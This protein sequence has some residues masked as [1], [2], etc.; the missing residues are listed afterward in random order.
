MAATEASSS[1]AAFQGPLYETSGPYF[2]VPFNAA[3]VTR[4]EVGTATLRVTFPNSGTLTYSVDGVP[5]T[6]QIR[7]QT[8]AMNDM[9]GEYTGS[10]GIRV[11][12]GSGCTPTVGG[13]AFSS[14]GSIQLAQSQTT[15]SMRGVLAGATCTFSGSYAQEGRLGTSTGTYSCSNGTSGTYTVS[16]IEATLYGF[17][18]KYTGTERG[19]AVEG[20]IGAT[21]TTIRGFSE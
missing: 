12:G 20:R 7:R 19:C 6:R 5:I 11:V 15:F 2:G 14:F 3:A 9:S 10:R 8:W 13:L 16:E 4:R 17:F 18:G 1:A 21:R